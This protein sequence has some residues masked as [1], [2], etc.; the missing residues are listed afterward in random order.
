MALMRT[1]RPASQGLIMAADRAPLDLQELVIIKMEEDEVA[2][3][4]LK[5]LPN[6]QAPAL[7][8]GLSRDPRQR[9]RSS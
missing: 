9:F 2:L 5:P 4:D 6:P 8:P 1:G 7:A 3:W